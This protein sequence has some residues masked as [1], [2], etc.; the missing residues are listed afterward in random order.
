MKSV[1]I[2]I[3]I[4]SSLL[5]Y[6]QDNKGY[7]GSKAYFS[8]ETNIN[9]PLFYN[10]TENGLSLKKHDK[11]NYGIRVSGNYIIKRNFAIG[12]ELAN[13]FSNILMSNLP[14]YNKFQNYDGT[15]DIDN[16]RYYKNLKL[17]T[18]SFIPKIEFA[19][20]NGLLPLGLSHQIGFGISKTSIRSGVY[21]YWLSDYSYS[22]INEA[23]DFDGAYEFTKE[24][25]PETIKNI[26]LL[27]A[28]NIR[29]ALTKKV[30]LS[31][32]FRYTL[33]INKQKNIGFLQQL[34]FDSQRYESK[35]ITQRFLNIIHFNLGLTYVL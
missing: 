24:N 4:F 5:S 22:Y 6:A 32:G 15:Y 26:T 16:Y 8:L 34:N 13:D 27:Y 14:N 18:F 31:Y 12:I 20:K 23:N 7:Y 28:L 29:T 2:S 17:S 9:T 30:L 35:V 21:D 25:R 1:I 19:T 3:I 10:L 11:I 33:N